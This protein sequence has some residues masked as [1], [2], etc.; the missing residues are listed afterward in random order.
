MIRTLIQLHRVYLAH[1]SLVILFP[2][3]RAAFA[4]RR[5]SGVRPAPLIMIII[6]QRTTL[7]IAHLVLTS[8]LQA[9]LALAPAMCVRLG[10]A[11]STPKQAPVALYALLGHLLERI[12]QDLA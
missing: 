1:N 4:I 6:L 8:R 7:P 2:P 12:L 3:T 10:K 9:C 5:H 11:T